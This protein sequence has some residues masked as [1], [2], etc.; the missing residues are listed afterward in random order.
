M[1]LFKVTNIRSVNGHNREPRYIADVIEVESGKVFKDAQ[2]LPNGPC[3][4]FNENGSINLIDGVLK[5][6]P[7][8]EYQDG[9]IFSSSQVI[10]ESDQF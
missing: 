5:N 3:F 1:A 7:I 9:D 2:Y 8:T 10:P 4:Y 6:I